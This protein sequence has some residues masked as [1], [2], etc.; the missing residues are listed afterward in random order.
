MKEA[1]DVVHEHYSKVATSQVSEAYAATLAKS[2]GYKEEELK[3][4]PKE[5]SLGLGCGNSVSAADL[6]PG[7]YILDLGC[8]AG[9]DLFLAASKISPTGKAFGVDFSE[10]MI[11]KGKEIQAKNSIKNVEF[12]HSPIEVMPFQENTF[13][14]VISNCVL[15]LVPDKNK[16]FKE[17]VRVMKPKGRFIVSD[18]VRKKDYPEDLKSDLISITTCIGRAITFEEYKNGLINAGLENIS[19]VDVKK[20][21]N[22]RFRLNPEAPSNPQTNEDAPNCETC[23][24]K[25]QKACCSKLQE[26]C[27]SKPQEACFSK[28]QKACCGGG[29]QEP[30]P[31]AV[32]K[33]DLN[34]YACSCLI[35]GYKK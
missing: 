6:K 12:I 33:Y 17:I 18:I 5:A 32:L 4:I 8:G 16:A 9:M 24:S 28:P 7:E 34:E 1:K 3:Q 14:V 10:D 19:M 21:L 26:A 27:C 15:N 13:D 22:E 20:D 23:S 30:V 11:K 29:A 2:A 35:K 25:P 31:S